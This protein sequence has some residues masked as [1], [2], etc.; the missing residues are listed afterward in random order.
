MRAL[1]ALAV[2]VA[3]LSVVEGVAGEQKATPEASVPGSLVLADFD[4]DGHLDVATANMDVNQDGG[5]VSVLRGTGAG[6]F[7]A[8]VTYE[9]PR[10]PGW[11][12]D[13]SDR[14]GIAATDLNG[15]R[16]PDLVTSGD[17]TVSVHINDGRGGLGRA[18]AYAVATRQGRPAPQLWDVALA[19]VN[20]DRRKDI[21]TAALQTSRVCVLLG[22]Q[23]GVFAP[24]KRYATVEG[25]GAL[26]VADLNR[27]GNPD[28]IVAGTGDRTNFGAELVFHP[29]RRDGRL[30]PHR[31]IE[32]SFVFPLVVARID[33]DRDPDLAWREEDSLVVA[34]GQGNGKFE[35]VRRYAAVRGAT[36]VALADF[37]GDQRL[38]AAVTNDPRLH[39]YGT[40]PI[41]ARAAIL[42]GKGDGSF[43]LL[44]RFDGTGGWMEELATGDLN[45]D[46]RPDLVATVI[47]PYW[48]KTRGAIR[49][50]LTRRNGSLSRPRTYAIDP[51]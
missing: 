3:V 15:D 10:P 22:R 35:R 23:G 16:A 18:V 39:D 42:L 11:T 46:A 47:Y 43:R 38:D 17:G 4:R 48:A 34:L 51:R 44:G 27:D 32:S 29:T 33:R 36:G 9:I 28:V 8:G 12:Q 30:R 26:E 5:R 41:R 45:G 20:H 19:D 6:A 14:T 2:V 50:W 13:S 49:V 25:P 1:L 37:N 21:I 7:R 31:P 40:P 24:V